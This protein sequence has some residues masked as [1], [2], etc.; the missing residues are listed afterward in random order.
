MSRTPPI[1]KKARK[2]NASPT[3]TASEAKSTPPSPSPTAT[4]SNSMARMSSITAAPR[5]VRAARPPSTPSS[6]STADVMP[7]LVAT[8]ATPTNTA[9]AVS[10][11]VA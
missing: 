1:A 6:I 2:P 11:P 7:T 8:S 10:S 9:V 4:A 3:V 5:I